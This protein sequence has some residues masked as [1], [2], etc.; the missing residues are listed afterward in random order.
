[1]DVTIATGQDKR[2][3]NAG[4]GNVTGVRALTVTRKAIE[5][6][7]VGQNRTNT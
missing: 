3:R 6:N 5:K 2:K 1:M 7:I 4:R